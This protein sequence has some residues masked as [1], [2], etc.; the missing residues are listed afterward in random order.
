MPQTAGVLFT[1][2]YH[3]GVQIHKQLAGR[4]ECLLALE[5]GGNNPLVVDR[6]HNPKAAI[7]S[8][9]QSAYITSGQRCTCA[10]RLLRCQSSREPW[11]PG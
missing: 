8:I 4:P 10:R 11:L 9:I 7:A 3:A 6:I 1:G 2:S 5:M